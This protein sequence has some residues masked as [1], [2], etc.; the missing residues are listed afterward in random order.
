[1]A[2]RDD[3]RQV[4]LCVGA[5]RGRGRRTRRGG[6][7]RECAA[8]KEQRPTDVPLSCKLQRWGGGGMREAIGG[9]AVKQRQAV[10]GAR[11]VRVPMVATI[12]E[13]GQKELPRAVCTRAETRHS[14]LKSH[15]C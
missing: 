1:M 12:A 4:E 13:L 5:L 6:G 11:T 15:W 14:A 9:A 3:E 2:L 7:G 8:G 10:R